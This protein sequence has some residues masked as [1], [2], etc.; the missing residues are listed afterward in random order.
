MKGLT[1]IEILIVIAIV[2]ILAVLSYASLREWNKSQKIE[3]DT[4]KI[5]A[6]LLE[7]RTKAFTEKVVCGA[8]WESTPIKKIHFRCDNDTDGD[9][10]DPNGYVE[11]KTLSLNT[12]FAA[13]FS[14]NTVTFYPEGYSTKWG[15]IYIHSTTSPNTTE[16]NCI[17]VSLIKIKMGHW[18]GSSCIAR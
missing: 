13:T 4:R 12:E 10:T 14:G 3:A 6:G 18:N 1:L 11:I 16:Y 7:A 15:T 17:T 5:Y 2:G 9:I 8:Y